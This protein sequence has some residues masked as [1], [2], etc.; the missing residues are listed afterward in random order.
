MMFQGTITALIT[1]FKNNKIDFSHLKKL[2]E[3]QIAAGIDG[4]V[5][6]GSTGEGSSLLESEYYELISTAINYANGK[7][8]IIAGVT[9]VHTVHVCR[10]I[11][12]LTTMNISGIMCT[13]PHYI[14]PEQEGLYQHFKAIH[15]ASS[16]PIMI[17]THP[18]RTGCDMSDDV[19]IKLSKL[20]QIIAVKDASN[21]IEKPLRILPHVSKNFH[22]L[23]GDDSNTLA[24]L[25]NGGVGCI[26]VISNI[27][28]KIAKRITTCCHSLSWDQARSLQISLMPILLA[29]RS[30]SNPIGIKYAASLMG[31]C[32]NEL[33]LPLTPAC[34]DI[35]Q[36]ISPMIENLNKLENNV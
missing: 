15:D 21:D 7:I 28:P 1:P 4:I 6:G 5:V 10:Q 22:F 16:V 8:P 32:N 2:V 34:I 35:M 33:R 23:T 30:E 20:P 19:I 36:K 26:S 29:M 24:Y 31:F 18:G 12:L 17:Y 13:A 14:R 25:A 11:Q 3:Y 9:G 27:V